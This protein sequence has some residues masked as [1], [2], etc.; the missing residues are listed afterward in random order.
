[1]KHYLPINLHRLFAAFSSLIA[2]SIACKTISLAFS[3]L[4]PIPWQDH[5]RLLFIYVTKGEV[6]IHDIFEQHN[7]HRIPVTH[8]IDLLDYFLF[9]GRFLLHFIISFTALTFQCLLIAAPLATRKNLLLS[10]RLIISSI[11]V[12]LTFSSAQLD[13]VSWPFCVG[14]V[15]SNMLVVSSLMTLQV[16]ID[17]GS[18][19]LFLCSVSSGV[20][21]MSGLVSG[22][23]IWPIGLGL[24]F[25][26]QRRITSY[27]IAWSLISAIALYAYFH[28]YIRP[29][30]HSSP[31]QTLLHQPTELIKYFILVL[32]SV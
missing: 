16:A 11:I 30:H 18:L 31:I 3:L 8:I 21:A 1:M 23:F 22:T 25:L 26:I 28:E 19:P 15:V 24:I 12:G 4:P 9:Q 5:W 6:S 10:D 32:G 17:R 2:I 13:T 7:E 27:S 29:Q 20:V 14:N